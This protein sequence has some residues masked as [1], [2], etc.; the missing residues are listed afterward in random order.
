MGTQSTGSSTIPSRVEITELVKATYTVLQRY[1]LK[2][3]TSAWLKEFLLHGNMEGYL[4][5]VPLVGLKYQELSMLVAKQVSSYFWV[6][7]RR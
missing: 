4:P 5:T 2:L 6:P 1:L 7:I 3:L